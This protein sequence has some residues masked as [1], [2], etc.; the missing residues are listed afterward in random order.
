MNSIPSHECR[1]MCCVCL[2]TKIECAMMMAAG[3]IVIFTI[4]CW[5]AGIWSFPV[6][7]I[8]RDGPVFFNLFGT[9]LCRTLCSPLPSHLHNCRFRD[10]SLEKAS[11][12]LSFVETTE[13]EF[14]QSRRGRCECRCPQTCR[15]LP[16]LQVLHDCPRHLIP[17][18]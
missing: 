2:V 9:L 12:V 18:D 14:F 15:G 8:L 13:V 3:S 4:P 10:P 17:L 6:Q 5:Q 7:N 1:H 16:I 11:G